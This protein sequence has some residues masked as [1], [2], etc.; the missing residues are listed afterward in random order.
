M[1]SVRV[2]AYKGKGSRAKALNGRL[3][4]TS[5]SHYEGRESTYGIAIYLEDDTVVARIEFTEAE[6]AEVAKNF[7]KYLEKK[8]GGAMKVTIA[9]LSVYYEDAVDQMEPDLKAEVINGFGLPSWYVDPQ[10]F[11]DA[12]AEV[13]EAKYG[14][15]WSVA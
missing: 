5:A 1:A 7:S 9:G 11:V 2:R 13:Y 4:G 6:A 14:E 8:G 12:Y 15:P 3:G 10:K